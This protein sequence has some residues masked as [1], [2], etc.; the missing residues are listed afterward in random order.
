MPLTA[1]KSAYIEG[2]SIT[3]TASG[4]GPVGRSSTI[5]LFIS[6]ISPSDTSASLAGSAG[7]YSISKPISF[8][9]SGI[10]SATFTIPIV[11]D[12]VVEGIEN[13]SFQLRDG[14][15]LN[16]SVADQDLP[17][18]T[19]APTVSSF[20][21][22]DGANSIA[23]GSNITVSFS[24]AIQRGSGNIEIRS[25]SA[26]GALVESFASATSDRLTFSESTLTI[27]PTSSLANNTQYFVTFAP[28]SVR[29]VAG[30]NYTDTSTYD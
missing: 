13:W 4:S 8:G 11:N 5:S 14:S 26:T 18:D 25:G 10:G 23:V 1:T 12:G 3:I 15:I 30:N 17:P 24:E 29:D 16:L 6:G 22:I 21:P 2:E 27:D 19:T 20:S 28:G 9:T 7:N